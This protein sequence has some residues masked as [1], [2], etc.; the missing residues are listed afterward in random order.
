MQRDFHPHAVLAQQVQE[1]EKVAVGMKA[2]LSVMPALR[3]VE[4]NSRQVNSCSAWHGMLLK[5]FL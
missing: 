1:L 2:A 3:D 4:G 5:N